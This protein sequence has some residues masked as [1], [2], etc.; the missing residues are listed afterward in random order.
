MCTDALKLLKK[1]VDEGA[2]LEGEGL[3]ERHRSHLASELDALRSRG[4]RCVMSSQPTRRGMR[5]GTALNRQPPLANEDHSSPLHSLHSGVSNTSTISNDSSDAIFAGLR[6]GENRFL[7]LADVPAAV[8]IV[9]RLVTLKGAGV[10]RELPAICADDGFNEVQRMI[11]ETM[12]AFALDTVWLV[13][14]MIQVMR[15]LPDLLEQ[16]LGAILAAQWPSH[17]SK[18]KSDAES[19]PV[20]SAGAPPTNPFIFKIGDAVVVDPLLRRSPP[21][22]QPSDHEVFTYLLEGNLFSTLRDYG[23]TASVALIYNCLAC[24][25]VIVCGDDVDEV[26]T[27]MRVASTFV[28]GLFQ[29]RG[30]R[31][32]VGLLPF[33]QS[34]GKSR[35][36]YEHLER[37]A[38]IGCPVGA[39]LDEKQ[40][41]ILGRAFVWHVQGSRQGDRRR[42]DA[43]RCRTIA[44]HGATY[45]VSKPLTTAAQAAERMGHADPFDAG[46]VPPVGSATGLLV[47]VA[48]LLGLRTDRNEELALTNYLRLTIKRVFLDLGMM[49]ACVLNSLLLDAQNKSHATASGYLTSSAG[50]SPMVVG[51]RPTPGAGGGSSLTSI[52]PS[53]HAWPAA[54]PVS[55]NSI[56]NTSMV[57]PSSLGSNGPLYVP[58]RYP[59]VITEHDVRRILRVQY[60][61]NSVHKDDVSIVTSMVHRMATLSAEYEVST[62]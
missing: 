22:P 14:N 23:V 19:T 8:E 38:V 27:A 2:T 11:Q 48:D 25:P 18:G 12:W 9:N 55:N 35:V 13:E 49:A 16:P 32:G 36:T 26:L 15:P 39:I 1:L 28:P 34:A 20:D 41:P 24:K 58:H 61:Y 31:L 5:R 6:K 62:K 10:L 43:P 56:G 52:P 30:E 33:E 44:F 53:M 51:R 45:D 60:G 59:F 40:H 37:Y 21:P 7:T 29:S 50:E 54:P 46:L 3:T 17:E 42:R 57:T 47:E 4:A